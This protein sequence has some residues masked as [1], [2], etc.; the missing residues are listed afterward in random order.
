LSDQSIP[1]LLTVEEFEQIPDRPGGHYELHHGEAMFMT[2]P[3]RQHKNLERFL[4]ELLTPIARP[5]GFLVDT[6]HPYRPLPE[7]DVWG[8]DV[9]TCMTRP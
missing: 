6:E 4:R 1:K 5:L 3:V 8:A 2:W 7:N 9:P